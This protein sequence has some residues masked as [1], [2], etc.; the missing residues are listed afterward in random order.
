MHVYTFRLYLFYLYYFFFTEMRRA[1]KD[2]GRNRCMRKIILNKIKLDFRKNRNDRNISSLTIAFSFKTQTYWFVLREE[3]DLSV[4]NLIYINIG[5][6][7]G[8]FFSVL[9]TTVCFRIAKFIFFSKPRKRM[10]FDNCCPS[11]AKFLYKQVLLIRSQLTP[12]NSTDLSLFF[13]FSLTVS[14]W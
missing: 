8:I 12:T 10:Y 3:F 1:Y 9:N 14:F 11:E 4:M 7:N 13:C 2:N 6:G 5:K